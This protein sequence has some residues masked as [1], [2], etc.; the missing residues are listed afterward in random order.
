MIDAA[1]IDQLRDIHLPDLVSPWPFALGWWIVI[2]IG[3]ML[4]LLLNF[5]MK[6][7][8]N[9]LIRAQFLKEL[10]SIQKE[11]QK[12][13][14]ANYALQKIA[15]TLKKAALYYYPRQVVAS[16]HGDEWLKFLSATSKDLDIA[17]CDKL[18]KNALYQSSYKED[19]SHVFV[20]AYQ[21]IKQQRPK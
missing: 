21:W 9:Y 7:Y 13:K 16:L 11:Y 2:I 15:R 17:R 20:L 3:L 19:V 1:V 6:Y 10:R 18:F 4:I 14:R 12:D 8:D 5:S